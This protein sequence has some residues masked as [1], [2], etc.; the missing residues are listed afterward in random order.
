MKQSILF[1]FLLASV[2]GHSQNNHPIVFGQ[3]MTTVKIDSSTNRSYSLVADNQ[4]EVYG[5]GEGDTLFYN[6]YVP[7]DDSGYPMDLT[8]EFEPLNNT[9]YKIVGI[10]ED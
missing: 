5:L 1:V 7:V 2:I 9:S 10:L 6:G 8:Y 4:Y 3:E